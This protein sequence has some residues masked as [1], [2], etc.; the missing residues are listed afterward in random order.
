MPTVDRSLTAL[1]ACAAAAAA[2]PI[3]LISARDGT[4]HRIVAAHGL[5]LGS[6]DPPAPAFCREVLQAGAPWIVEDTLALPGLA[7]D[8]MVAGPPHVRCCA[9]VPLERDGIVLG[10][11]CVLDIRPRAF[12][13]QA[14]DALRGLARATAELLHAGLLDAELA[15]ERRRLLDFARASGDWMWEA[16]AGLRYT[17]ISGAFEALTG[18][19]PAARL[20]RQ[21][22]DG[23]LL[24]ARGERARGTLHGLLHAGQ[25]FSRVL[26][27]KATPLGTRIVSRSAVPVLDGLGQLVGWRGTARDVTATIERARQQRAQDELLQQL[28]DQAP[29]VIFQLHHDGD[30]S[31]R[32]AFVNRRSVDLLGLTPDELIADPAAFE[33][34]VHPDDR[35]A[36]HRAFAANRNRDGGAL[37]LEYRIVRTDG[38][39]RW[40][41]ATASPERRTDG[42]ITWRGFL[43]DITEKK[44]VE[45]AL[46]TSE[47]RWAIAAETNGIG[48]VQ[49]DLAS[50]RL[51]FDA[52]ACAHHG[53]THPHADYWLADWIS[54]VHPDD[55]AGAEAA[56][57]AA[58]QQTGLLDARCRFMRSDGSMPWLEV[59]ARLEPPEHGGASTSMIGTC[60]DVTEQVAIDDLRREKDM[61]ARASRAKSEFLSR[62]SHELRTPL[63]GILGFAQLMALDHE[64]PLADAQRLRLDGVRRSGEHLLAL[65]NDVLDIARIEQDDYRPRLQPVDLAAAA[66]TCLAMVHP[67]ASA[68]GVVL[69]DRL[70]GAAW[71]QADARALEQVLINLLSNAIKFN[72]TGGRVLVEVAER[73]GRVQLA[74]EDEGPGLSA[75]QQSQLF[76]PFN[77]L[78]AERRRIEGNGLGL[79]IS[80]QLARAMRGD[81]GVTSAPG[82]GCRFMLELPSAAPLD[83]DDDTVPSVLDALPDAP[84]APRHVLYIED[85]PLNVLLMQEV[86]RR[87]AQWVLHTARDGT[88]GLALTRSLRP[89]LLLV[90][91]NLPDISGIAIIRALRADPATAELHCIALS[92]DAMSEQIDAARA[93]GFD[94]YWTK[95]IDVTQLTRALAGSFARGRVAAP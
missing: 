27:E 17:W 84:E 59:I 51:T 56:L 29:G 34:L 55:R 35:D 15:D 50:G 3:A 76:Q 5:A 57:K 48:I 60:R 72:R 31:R 83:H 26:T 94:D 64:H 54:A 6:A 47:H 63:N 21:I 41:S 22:V 45:L 40:V 12:D 19:P 68:R 39:E 24:D 38:E 7:D 9:G 10:T 18:V 4:R 43:A 67:L 87:N 11:L 42:G 13:A 69:A 37:Q 75:A 14:G 20:G 90:D 79:V 30:G 8:A 74:V 2:C 65:I 49:L 46:R 86:F 89:D 33:R 93:A 66:S 81:L 71:A 28:S 53:L 92:A 23:A 95:P 44:R 36:V 58:V 25:P 73:D 91:I 82:R 52:R 80:R 78:G 61:I 1:A 70:A 32:I 77:R 16:D 85:E 62:V 88:E